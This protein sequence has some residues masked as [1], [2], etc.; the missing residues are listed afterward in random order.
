MSREKKAEKEAWDPIS[1]IR[2]VACN[3][4]ELNF[5]IYI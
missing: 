2:V 4:C 3:K 1:A 5:Y